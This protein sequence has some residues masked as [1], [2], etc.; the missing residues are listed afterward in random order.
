MVL[1]NKAANNRPLIM[2]KLLEVGIETR[3]SFIP[4]NMQDIFITKGWTCIE[5]C[6]KANK[7]ATN[8]F[9]LPSGPSLTDEELTYVVMN[10]KLVLESV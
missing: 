9:Y 4:Y 2:K 10:L 6:P 5:D 1:K 7:I 8:G 3:E